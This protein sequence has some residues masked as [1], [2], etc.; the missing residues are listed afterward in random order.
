MAITATYVNASSFT[1]VGDQT[2][3]FSEGRRVKCNC[4]VDGNKIG[5]IKSS[6]YTSL[7]TIILTLL[8]DDLTSNLTEVLYGIQSQG[9]AGS[10]PVHNH[11]DGEGAGGN[12]Q[13]NILIN[14]DFSIWQENTTFAN[15]ATGVYTADGHLVE[16]AA[17]GGTLPTVNVKENTTVHEDAFSQSCELEITNVGATGATRFWRLKQSIEDWERYKGKTVTVS[18]RLKS[19]VAITLPNGLLQVHDG[20]SGGYTF[21][22]SVTTTWTTYSATLAISTSATSMSVHFYIIGA[23]AG[24]ISTTGSIYIQWMKLE[25]GSVNTP[26]IPRKTGK[27]LRLCQR[28]YQK[29]YSQGTFPGA[30][31]GVGVEEIYTAGLT[32]SVRLMR[33]NT[34]LPVVMKAAPTVTVYSTA[35]TSGNVTMGNGDI[36]ATVDNIS[37]S[38]FRVYATDTPAVTVGLISYQYIAVSRV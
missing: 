30:V 29:S 38:G 27:E 28:Y 6:V 7:T 5:T 35:G 2:V 3:E 32:S 24:E 20:L 19:S 22:T 37:D 36:S 9:S 21:I 1:V 18:I 10:V 15:P 33:K 17:G 16:S 23:A 26:L 12:V 31:T 14:Q 8:S 34:R 4:G 11:G 25:L 13:N